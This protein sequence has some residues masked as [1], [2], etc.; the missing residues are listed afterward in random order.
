MRRLTWPVRW[1][2]LG[3]AILLVP[4]ATILLVALG[5]VFVTPQVATLGVTVPGPTALLCGLMIAFATVATLKEPTSVLPMVTQRALPLWRAARVLLLVGTAMT[6]FI[7]ASPDHGLAA[8]SCVC[9][10]TAESLLLARLLWAEIA[11]SLPLLHAGLTMTFGTNEIGD[12]RAW[13]WILT[14]TPNPAET[15][16]SAGL[17]AI[18]VVAW[19]W[20]SNKG[21]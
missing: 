9:A 6:F 16:V 15:L 11:W 12:I 5:P 14:P 2:H 8:V 4:S 13:A 18:G 17:L 19:A 20:G 21:R 10:L 1:W 3:P 7:T